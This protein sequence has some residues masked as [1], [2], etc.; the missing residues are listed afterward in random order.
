GGW[1]ADSTIDMTWSEATDEVGGSGLDRYR[2]LFDDQ[3]ATVPDDTTIVPHTTDPHTTTS[4]ALAD[5]N[6]YFH[7]STCDVA[8]NCTSTVHRGPY[9]IDTTAPSAAGTVS[10][11]SH[12]ATPVADTTVDAS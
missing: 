6:W 8:G 7:L 4:A 9:G 12:S 3:P 2:V 5:G 10:S 11:S 1:V